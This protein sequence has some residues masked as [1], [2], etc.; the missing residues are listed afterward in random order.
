M[1]AQA[2]RHTYQRPPPPEL[3]EVKSAETVGPVLIHIVTEK[4]RGYQPA[5]TASDKMHGVVKFDPRT[6]EQQKSK[7]KVGSLTNYFAGELTS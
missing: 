6:G 7:A 1:L 2:P 4:G 3:A 5:E